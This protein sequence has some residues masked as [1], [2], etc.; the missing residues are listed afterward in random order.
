MHW[1]NF[2]ILTVM[3][4]SGLR[5]YW[6]DLRHPF[7]VGIAGWHWFDLFPDGFNEELGLQQEAI[8]KTHHPKIFVGRLAEWP[9]ERVEFALRRLAE[10]ADAEEHQAIRAFLGELLPEASL[11]AAGP[12][13]NVEATAEAPHDE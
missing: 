3:I 7:G 13:R 9:G 11:D 5:I 1:I 6:A 10:L 8:A 12:E 2:P 4:W